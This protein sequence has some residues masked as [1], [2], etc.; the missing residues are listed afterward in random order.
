[1]PKRLITL[2]PAAAVALPVPPSAVNLAHDRPLWIEDGLTGGVFFPLITTN[3]LHSPWMVFNLFVGTGGMVALVLLAVALRR[4]RWVTLVGAALLLS[5]AMI[6]VLSV[7]PVPMTVARL[8]DGSAYTPAD[9]SAGSQPNFYMGYLEGSL[10]LL[11]SSTYWNGEGWEGLSP[12]WFSAAFTGSAVLLILSSRTTHRR[13][14]FPVS[15]PA[16]A[17]R[18]PA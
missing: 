3:G 14:P 1:L 18:R 2:W 5:V 10:R 4:R 12:L 8:I 7:V 16:G 15:A 17:P 13:R 11:P 6:G 9:I